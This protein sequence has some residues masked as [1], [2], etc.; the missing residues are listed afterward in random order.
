MSV[1]RGGGGGGVNREG[2]LFKGE[3]FEEIWYLW[4][5]TDLTEEQV[6]THDE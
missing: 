4:Y 2:E 1:P 6:T 5:Q 3:L